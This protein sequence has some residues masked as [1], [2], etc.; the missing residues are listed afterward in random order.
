M[1]F[2]SIT[3]ALS[4]MAAS[5]VVGHE[6]VTVQTENSKIEVTDHEVR[7]TTTADQEEIIVSVSTPEQK[8][9][10]A[11]VAAETTEEKAASVDEE[12]K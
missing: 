4:F 5:T 2:K 6:D 7:V 11:P 3:L 8:E 9:V 10:V 12:T 1:K